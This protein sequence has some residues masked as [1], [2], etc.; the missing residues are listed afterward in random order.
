MNASGSPL[1][2]AQRHNILLGNQKKA[3]NNRERSSEE[4]KLLSLSGQELKNH[5][6]K[7][8][9]ELKKL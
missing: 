4:L 6:R 8:E 3:E 5:I 9:Q 1:S 7:G 2:G